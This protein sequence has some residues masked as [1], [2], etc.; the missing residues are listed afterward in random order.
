MIF[1]LGLFTFI[2]T[3]SKKIEQENKIITL[4]CFYR[5]L[6]A[7]GIYIISVLQKKM[8]V[9]PFTKKCKGHYLNF[10]VV[11]NWNSFVKSLQVNNVTHIA[12]AYIEYSIS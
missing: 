7:L 1:D 3:F 11:I 6:S 5:Y 8:N 9:Y 4:W 2:I 10:Y 12:H